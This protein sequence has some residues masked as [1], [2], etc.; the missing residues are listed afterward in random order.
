M[1]LLL[2]FEDFRENDATWDNIIWKFQQIYH[3]GVQSQ[4]NNNTNWFQD[5]FEAWGIYYG[6]NFAAAYI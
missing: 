3:L 6:F 1:V 2:Y 5:N 4:E